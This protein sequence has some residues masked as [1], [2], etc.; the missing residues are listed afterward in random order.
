ML[1]V[2]NIE[3]WYRKA[4]AL[5]DIKIELK[6][7]EIVAILG[8]NGAGKTTLLNTISG[9]LNCKKGSIEFEGKRIDGLP[10]HKVVKLGLAQISQDRNLFP[11]MSVMDNLRLGAATQYKNKE[12]IP[13]LLEM[14]FS[15]FPRLKERLKQKASTLSGGEQQ[16]LAIGRVLMSNPKVILM[17]EASTGL[18][19]IFVEKIVEAIRLLKEAGKDIIVVE[20]N[21]FMPFQLADRVYILR[22]GEIVSSVKKDQLS[23]NYKD[24]AE[25]V[26]SSYF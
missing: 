26:S 16:M 23:S 18:A 8:T 19:P 2:N 15:Y 24:F 10:P 11:K 14:V 22:N 13:K 12:E 4:C 20:Q 7:Q 1:K 6:R 17:D 25:F 5:R 21:L 3:V 9:F